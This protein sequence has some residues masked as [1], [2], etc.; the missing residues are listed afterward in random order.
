[1]SNP[2]PAEQPARIPVP[3]DTE[4]R[5]AT[6]LRHPF[7]APQFVLDRWVYPRAFALL[8]GV[9]VS[10][11]ILL[12]G[13]PLVEVVRGATVSLGDGVVL[14]SRNTDY[15]V[16]MHSPVKLFADRPGAEI[17]IGANSRIHGTCIHAHRSVRIG[18]RCLVAA[19]TQIFDG[20]GHD[21]SFPN[22]E[23]RIHTRGTSKPIVIED[24]VWVGA[25]CIIL[26]GVHVGRG[27]VLA[28]G[29]VVSQDIPPYS[30]AAGNPAK[31]VRRY[32]GDIPISHP[33]ARPLTEDLRG[34]SSRARGPGP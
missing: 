29:S 2:G 33:S 10:G 20:S 11:R 22:V 5:I 17:R 32:G 26:P 27:A 24:D 23:R 21:L 1:M 12:K 8:R 19:N 31:V 6:I 25:N 4:P 28:A 7:R 16:N 9:Q 3:P 34:A 18:A 14:N 30:L 13:W 15:H